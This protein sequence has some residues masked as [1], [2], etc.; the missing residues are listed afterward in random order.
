MIYVC[1]LFNATLQLYADDTAII[2]QH[3]DIVDLDKYELNA[4]VKEKY[5]LNAGASPAEGQGGSA[6]RFSF[7]PPPIYFLSPHGIF[8]GRKTLLFLAGK[9]VKICDFGQKNPS[10]FGEDLLFCF[11]W[12][13]PNFR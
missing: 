11:F 3:K 7:L 5:E 4:R 9:N 6:P 12:I 2:L 10:D 13:S 8:L 1:F